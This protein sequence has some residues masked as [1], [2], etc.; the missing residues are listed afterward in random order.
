[1]SLTPY[2]M[3]IGPNLT[4][5]FFFFLLITSSLQ[6]NFILFPFFSII[7]YNLGYGGGGKG[8]MPGVGEGVF[9]VSRPMVC[10]INMEVQI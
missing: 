3:L 4:V 10:T 1:M 9:F 5:C 7:K 2:H 6:D 8:V